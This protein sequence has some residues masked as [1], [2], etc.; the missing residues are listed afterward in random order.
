M[1]TIEAIATVTADG[2]L[3]LEIPVENIEIGEHRVVIDAN[4]VATM[5]A[6][7]ISH[8]LTHNVADFTRFAPYITVVP[9]MP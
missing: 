5:V 9:L 8:L 6:N 2:K 4:I 1:K 7:N 3:R